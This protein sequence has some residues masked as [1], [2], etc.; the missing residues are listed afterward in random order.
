MHAQKSSIA[1]AKPARCDGLYISALTE[2]C[3]SH[4]YQEKPRS[5][6]AQ[7]RQQQKGSDSSAPQPAA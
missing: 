3:S 5:G 1:R 7:R 6:E 2:E 4:A